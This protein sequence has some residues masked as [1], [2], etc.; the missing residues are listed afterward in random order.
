MHMPLVFFLI[1]SC[2]SA[3][4][5]NTN[6]CPQTVCTMCA[7]GTGPVAKPSF[8]FSVQN[9]SFISDE[10]VVLNT[11]IGHVSSSNQVCISVA[12]I[13]NQLATTIPT[14]VSGTVIATGV[15]AT[16]VST[17]GVSATGVS[18]TGISS[19][20]VSV[21]GVSTT[22]VS[23]TGISSTGVSATGVSATG[24]SATGVSATGVS[25]TGVSATG[26]SATGV[27]AR[28]VMEA[29]VL[30]LP[31][32]PCLGCRSAAFDL[33]AF[34]SNRTFVARAC[35]D[36][37]AAC[38]A[39][40]GQTK[41]N[42]DQ[43]WYQCTIGACSNIPFVLNQTTSTNSTRN[44]IAECLLQTECQASILQAG[45]LCQQYVGFQNLACSC[46]SGAATAAPVTAT[47]TIP[48]L[49]NLICPPGVIY[50]PPLITG[51]STNG[52]TAGVSNN[53]NSNFIFTTS[54]SYQVVSHMGVLIGSFFISL[55]FLL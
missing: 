37:H 21:T 3:V 17:T 53:G 19:T 45:L 25:A 35:C 33:G 42:C 9:V 6:V 10:I 15:S 22:G 54:D 11:N 51:V 1:I 34:P 39:T 18:T 55:F 14:G 23:A 2:L 36:A 12:Q 20:G 24:V 49:N 43:L 7:S 8:L 27:A 5:W 26:V 4:A 50:S 31:G 47:I 38:Y 46:V 32:I 41:A 28:E 16:G 48:N 29:T 40:C 13:I 52:V 30:T 44:L